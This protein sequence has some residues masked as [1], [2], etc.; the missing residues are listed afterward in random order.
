MKQNK[1]KLAGWKP[2]L[3]I[4]SLRVLNVTRMPSIPSRNG[5]SQRPLL[6]GARGGFFSWIQNLKCS[7]GGLSPAKCRLFLNAVDSNNAEIFTWRNTRQTCVGGDRYWPEKRC[8]NEQAG[9]LFPS[10]WYWWKET[11]SSGANARLNY[12]RRGHSSFGSMDHPREWKKSRHGEAKHR[13]PFRRSS[14]NLFPRS[15]AASN[16]P[17]ICTGE[18]ILPWCL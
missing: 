11:R 15:S 13:P 1:R 3:Q 16:R 2:A 9:L 17:A 7:A 6:G 10:L 18:T 12:G 4:C 5:N 14:P 8:W